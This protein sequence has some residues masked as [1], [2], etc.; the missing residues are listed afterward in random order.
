MLILVAD[1][2]GSSAFDPGWVIATCALVFTVASFWWIHARQGKLRGFE[3]H[4]YAAVVGGAELLLIRLP[5]VLYN[6]GPKPIVVQNLRLMFPDGP[7]GFG[8]LPWRNTRSQLKPVPEDLGDLP[9][10]FA[11]PG[12]TAQPWFIEFGGPFPGIVPEAREYIVRVEAKLGHRRQDWTTVL[13]FPLRAQNMTNPSAYIAHSNNPWYL[14]EEERAKVK[15]A[16]QALLKQ[17]RP[18]SS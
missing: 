5:L 13:T 7:A 8:G 14:S 11:V 12:R 1:G 2:D 15:E 17:L 6:T 3:P 9:A 10:V 18:D 16:G 4:T